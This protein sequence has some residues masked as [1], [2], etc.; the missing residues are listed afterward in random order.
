M[1]A[2]C[3]TSTQ[4]ILLLLVKTK[5]FE[6]M[7]IFRSGSVFLYF[8]LSHFW[9]K[10]IA[11]KLCWPA[12]HL[13]KTNVS[14]FQ[15]SEAWDFHN[16]DMSSFSPQQQQVPWGVSQHCCHSG[17]TWRGSKVEKTQG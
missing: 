10:V 4:D 3:I 5:S 11:I 1:E 13:I 2:L 9:N 7:R 17:H 6:Y 8:I 15:L 12:G 16:K 14:L